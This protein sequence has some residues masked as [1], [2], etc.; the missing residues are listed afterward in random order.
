MEKKKVNLNVAQYS[1]VEAIR[2]GKKNIYLEWARGAGKST[3]LGWMAI[4]AV[5]QLPRATGIL[6]GET[7]MK[8][9]SKTLP[10]TKEGMEMFGYYEDIDYVVG[11]GGK[12][13]GFELP[14][15]APNRWDNVIH[16]RNG[17]ILAL[18]SLDNANSGRG[19]NSYIVIGDEAALL[20]SE[21][22]FYN[23]QSTNR[24]K[25]IWFNKAP[26]LN[27]EIF[28]SSTPMS[29]RGK[30]FTDV[31]MHIL[32]AYKGVSN[33]IKKP[34]EWA[35]IKANAYVNAHMLASDY[36][37]KQKANAPSLMHF[38]AEILNIRPKF[39]EE[40]FYPQL[41]PKKHYYENFNN[42]YLESLGTKTNINSF[43]CKQDSDLKK[44]K[45]LIV[46]LDWG[47]FNSMVI[48]QDDGEEWRFLKSLW[49]K[50]PKI[51]DDLVTEEFATYYSSHA[52]KIIYLYYDRNGNNRQ[53]NS[54]LTL[55]EQAVNAFKNQ[56]W[57]VVIK[58][59]R[60]LD[61]PHHEKFIV[62]NYLLKSGGTKGLPKIQIN[63]HNAYDLTVSL[64]NTPAKEGTRGIQKDK[65]SER[66]KSIPQEHA[67]HLSD[68]FDL[69]IYWR[70]KDKVMK[71][72]NNNVERWSVP[73]FGTR[74]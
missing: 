52:N 33:K 16:F 5:I 63:M 49:V 17:F 67:T 4:Q 19:L 29:L 61:P 22:L 64:E 65:S 68:A 31:E 26:L 20:D 36:F 25:K 7:Y 62:I 43:N 18:V 40:S 3:I 71:L 34:N 30:W 45:P 58:T 23:V 57:K 72:I 47:V 39:I 11:S 70:Y 32:N 9:L 15:Q 10:S 69:A 73:I 56:G 59:P 38:E 51:I 74:G 27:A 2:T 46:Q 13:L 44:S 35:F 24:A 48:S 50:S 55:A 41:D 53:A 54:R 8:I 12:K 60:T 1:V 66:S 42:T 6:V 37:D 21:K 14:F 28:A